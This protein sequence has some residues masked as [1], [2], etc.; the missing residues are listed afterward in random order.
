MKYISQILEEFSPKQR[1]FVLI[2]LLAFMSVTF[3]VT[4]YLKSNSSQCGELVKE[5]RELLHDLSE[6]T[7]FARKNLSGSVNV[8]V[9]QPPETHPNRTKK[10]IKK[11]VTVTV[12]PDT[13]EPVAMDAPPPPPAAKM[14][15][16][17]KQVIQTKAFKQKLVDSLVKITTRHANLLKQ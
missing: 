4:S 14:V 16:H 13:N 17:D 15:I 9:P 1:L 6:A 12:A 11:M 8:T 3:I 10:A 5:N 2:V 7:D